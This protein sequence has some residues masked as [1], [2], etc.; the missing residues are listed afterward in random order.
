VTVWVLG[1]A[2]LLG[3]LAGALWGDIRVRRYSRG[4]VAGQATLFGRGLYLSRT[5]DGTWWRVWLRH[6]V[7]ES[8]GGGASDDP[9]PDSGVREPRRP[10][11]SSP[12][13]AA[14]KLLPPPSA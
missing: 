10:R 7:C 6:R 5:P 4:H 12:A 11:P 8:L 13:A 9:P 2:L 1:S 14:G 3:V